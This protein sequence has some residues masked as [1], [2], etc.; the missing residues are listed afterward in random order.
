MV[1]LVVVYAVGNNNCLKSVSMSCGSGKPA[2]AAAAGTCRPAPANPR[3]DFRFCFFFLLLLLFPPWT[4]PHRL[5]RLRAVFGA[6]AFCRLLTDWRPYY[7]IILY[8]GSWTSSTYSI[9][10]DAPPRTTAVVQSRKWGFLYFSK[11]RSF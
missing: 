4:P 5:R 6:V 11:I 1:Y 9:I 10:Q 7:T 8:S 3:A 2:A